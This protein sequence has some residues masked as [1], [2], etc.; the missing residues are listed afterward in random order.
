M[1]ALLNALHV[2]PAYPE[3]PITNAFAMELLVFL[4]LMAYFVVVRVTLSVEKPGAVQHLAEMT[5]E[6]VSRAG[7]ADY[8]PRLRAVRQLS[9]RRCCCSF[10]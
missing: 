4:V 8:R 2:H 5:N 7:R 6:F 3:A 10:C 9:D 1:T